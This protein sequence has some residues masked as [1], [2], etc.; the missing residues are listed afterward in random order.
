[1]KPPEKVVNLH[2]VLPNICGQVSSY[3]SSSSHPGVIPNAT[4]YEPSNV[5]FA[6]LNSSVEIDLT[7]S[8]YNS[9]VKDILSFVDQ[10]P[11]LRSILC[12]TQREVSTLFPNV[13]IT[14]KITE[15]P[16]IS[17]S[18]KI[19]AYIQ[20]NDSPEEVIPKFFDLGERWMNKALQ[21]AK[22]KLFITVEYK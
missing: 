21:K 11:F 10:Y 17:G 20:T 15:D 16:E 6:R 7:T 12:E 18:E 1:M 19:T 3:L 22:N 13:Q 9:N 14:L 5:G 8:R 2:S 4:I